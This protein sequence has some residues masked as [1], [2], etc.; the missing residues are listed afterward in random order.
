M[1]IRVWR[2]RNSW[3]EHPSP[4]L[5]GLFGGGVLDIIS[6]TL[7]YIQL[8]L[9]PSGPP[10]PSPLPPS[11]LRDCISMGSLATTSSSYDVKALTSEDDQLS[12]PSPVSAGSDK[13]IRSTCFALAV[14]PR[15]SVAS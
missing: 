4:R 8:L 14:P 1:W 2:F 3:A 5:Y 13:P 15:R 6:I 12:W 9:Q 7:N 11:T 10:S